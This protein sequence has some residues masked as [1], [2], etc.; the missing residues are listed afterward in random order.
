MA[1][2]NLAIVH[3]GGQ[4]RKYTTDHSPGSGGSR[5]RVDIADTCGPPGA[6]S[7][8]LHIT[9]IVRA[10]RAQERRASPG[11]TR[12]LLRGLRDPA[13]S[14]T[15]G[16]RTRLSRNLSASLPEDHGIPSP[17]RGD[18]LRNRR[19]E[20]RRKQYPQKGGYG[21]RSGDSPPFAQAHIMLAPSA[22]EGHWITRRQCLR[23]LAKKCEQRLAANDSPPGA[24]TTRTSRS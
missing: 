10:L 7:G 16:L 18:R 24:G 20:Q 17:E 15:D 4:S 13:R 8:A 23:R 2:A 12:F 3:G 21:L 1:K 11:I 14:W 22:Y 19:Q 6:I 5:H 9:S